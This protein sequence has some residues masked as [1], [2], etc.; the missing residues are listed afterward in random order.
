M[1]IYIYIYIY[2]NIISKKYF[3]IN[4]LYEFHGPVS[5]YLL[6]SEVHASQLHL[7]LFFVNFSE[8]FCF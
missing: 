3:Y 7:E 6:L 8:T 5:Y 4:I 1:P 2:K